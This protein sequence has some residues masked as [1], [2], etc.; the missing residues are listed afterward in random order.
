MNNR[1][2]A[3]I[4]ALKQERAH[5]DTA[6]KVLESVHNRPTAKGSYKATGKRI[7][8]PSARRRIAAAQRKRW[9][10]FRKQK[11]VA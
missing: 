2:S 7:L 9:A 10:A 3:V 4:V 1:L 8:S 6:I 11:R 5:L